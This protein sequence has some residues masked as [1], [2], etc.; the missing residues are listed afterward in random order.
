MRRSTRKTR[1]RLEVLEGRR[2]PSYGVVDLGALS[3]SAINN[4]GV[5]VGSANGHAAVEHSGVV[6]DLGTLGGASS[7]AKDI[8]S[9]GQVVGSAATPSGYNHAFLVTPEDTDGDGTPDLWFRDTDHNGVNDLMTDLGST[10]STA[11]PR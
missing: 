7:A 9:Y 3:P 10:T 5:V 1:L 8:N 6:T 2:T 4:A 11:S